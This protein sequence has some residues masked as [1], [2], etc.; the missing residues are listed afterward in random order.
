MAIDSVRI[1]VPEGT[2]D[3]EVLRALFQSNEE[4]FKALAHPA[5]PTDR[6]R[7]RM[8]FK[9]QQRDFAETVQASF[10]TVGELSGIP[11]VME[12]P[13]VPKAL[14]DDMIGRCDRIHHLQ[15]GILDKTFKTHYETAFAHGLRAG[16]ATRE[17]VQ[18]E[19]EMVKR[20]RLN[21][22]A[23]AQNFLTDIV[24]AEGT[25]SYKRRAKLYGQ[26]LEEAYWMG[27][28]YADLSADRYIQWKLGRGG[29]GRGWKE[30][31][32]CPDCSWLSGEGHWLVEDGI[33]EKL[34]IADEAE[35]RARGLGGRWGNGVYL[36]RE[37]AAMGIFPQSGKLTCTTN[38]KCVI[39][40]AKRPEGKPIGK[41]LRRP[42]RSLVPKEFTGTHRGKRGKVVVE[43]ERKLARRVRYAQRA[44]RTE[45]KHKKRV[46][47]N[48]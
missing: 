1:H 25:M 33:F 8:M 43:R 7:A 30:A 39:V 20:L 37:L 19:E 10:D 15:A 34:G 41:E 38:C 9:A 11:E 44:A 31:E 13:H 45:H 6:A 24:Q 23:Y 36:A 21:E 29:R 28:V 46:K 2:T 26:A 14:K 47:P 18:N 16:G 32:H 22:N 4:L 27:Y 12:L 5:P 42:F 35:A 3:E 17:M 40:P 48:W